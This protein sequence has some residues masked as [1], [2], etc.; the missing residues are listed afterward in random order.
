MSIVPTPF[1]IEPFRAEALEAAGEIGR[2]GRRPARPSARPLRPRKPSP[3]RP[4]QGG[5]GGSAPFDGFGADP[6]YA[7]EP[8][9]QQSSAPEPAAAPGTEHVRWLQFT[10]NRALGARLPVDGIMRASTRA[11]LRAFQRRRGL[12][13]SGYV[14]PD[15]RSA[16]L[17]VGEPGQFGADVE[18]EWD[19]GS[20]LYKPEACK[21]ANFRRQQTIDEALAFVAASPNQN[22]GVYILTGHAGGKSYVGSSINLTQRLG[23]HKKRHGSNVMV[24]LLPMP[25]ATECQIRNCECLLISKGMAR[26]TV[27]NV[28][29]Y[30]LEGPVI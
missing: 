30:E 6:A 13:V 16:L 3:W 9:P 28:R 26:G 11:A 24:R 23:A 1:E 10:L 20:H 7:P 8:F 19:P 22:R 5:A 29:T 4:S 25:G 17:A 27:T 15:T 12:P 2:R 14:G 18:S 21:P